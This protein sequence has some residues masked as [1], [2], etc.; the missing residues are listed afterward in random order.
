MLSFLK[1]QNPADLVGKKAVFIAC[2][3][4]EPYTG[5]LREKRKSLFE[6]NQD[7]SLENPH[8]KG[9]SLYNPLFKGTSLSNPP[10]K[11]GRGVTDS[12]EITENL[13]E[14]TGAIVIDIRSYASYEISHIKG[15][16]S[17]PFED[18]RKYLGQ[19]YLPFPK[20]SKLI[21]V[22]P[23]GEESVILANMA[24]NLGYDASSLA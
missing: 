24:K 18:L 20:E 11:G 19:D 8:F 6:D 7:F 2:D 13:D 23:F 3:R 15:S 14:N 21:F 12:A 10:S 17:F 22:C 4:L 1:K 9:T 16:L 5:Y